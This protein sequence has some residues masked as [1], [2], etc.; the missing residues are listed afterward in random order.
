[1]NGSEKA[2][3]AVLRGLI[4]ETERRL[5]KES[6]AGFVDAIDAFSRKAIRGESLTTKVEVTGPDAEPAVEILH[7]V[8][9]H[10]Q[11]EAKIAAARADRPKEV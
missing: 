8:F 6:R 4:I 7:A 11:D 1:M 9:R 3:V 10:L 5:P 2:I